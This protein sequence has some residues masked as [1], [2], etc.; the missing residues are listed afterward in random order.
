LHV[1]DAIFGQPLEVAWDG[2]VIKSAAGP[3]LAQRDAEI[4]VTQRDR[5]PGHKAML[6]HV[7]G[8]P[9]RHPTVGP[10]TPTTQ[11]ERFRSH[12]APRGEE[13]RLSQ[14]LDGE[15]DHDLVARLHHLA[16]TVV[17]DLHDGAAEDI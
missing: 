12:S 9:R 13:R 10:G 5:T 7:G 14:R 16:A 15:C 8:A 2:R 3:R 11:S 1:S 17:T 6:G 4:F